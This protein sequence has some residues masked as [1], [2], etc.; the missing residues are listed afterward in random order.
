MSRG[1]GA[2]PREPYPA[3]VFVMIHSGISAVSTFAT[4][5]RQLA[6]C[7]LDGAF[8]DQSLPLEQ[9][10]TLFQSAIMRLTRAAQ[11]AQQDIDEPNV[12][13]TESAERTPLNEIA[14][15]ASP[16]QAVVMEEIHK[17]TP[18]RNKSKKGGKKGTK[19]K[20]GKAVEAEPVEMAAQVEEEIV[21]N[22]V[23]DAPVEEKTEEA[24]NGE[25]GT[26]TAS[27]TANTI[28]SDTVES[29]TVEDRPASPAHKAVRLTR[30]QLAKQEEEP[31]QSQQP[32]TS[33]KVEPVEEQPVVDDIPR[34]QTEATV[35]MEAEATAEPENVVEAEDPLDAMHTSQAAD[36]AASGAQED[37]AFEDDEAADQIGEKQAP[38][39]A[40]A[41]L[42]VV[43]PIKNVDPEREG[44]EP[45]IGITSDPEPK[46]LAPERPSDACRT[47][48]ISR[49]SS[50]RAS[51]SPSKSPMRI[52]E[53]IEALDALEEALENVGKAVSHFDPSTADKSPRKQALP[54]EAR[55]PSARTKT[56]RKTTLASRV[57]RTPSAAPKSIKPTT[58]ALAR[59]SS[60]RVAPAK[61]LR[62]RSTE[63]VDYLASNRRPV[64]ISFPT[65]P[66][67][68]K[69]RAPTKPTFQLSSDAVAAKLKAQKEERLKREAEREARGVVPKQRPI[70]MPPVAKSTKA[71]TKATFQL[72]GEAVAAK[73]K[74]QK[75]ERLNR[76]AQS[77]Q[78]DQPKPR[79]VSISMPPPTMKSTKA[80]TKANFQLP[81]EAVAA[82]LKAQREERQKREEEAGAVKK[83]AASK[84]RSAPIR[85]PVALP[86]RSQPGVTI[87]PP[88][89]KSDTLQPPSQRSASTSSKRN[90]IQASRSTSV[91]TTASNRNSVIV[92]KAMVT[93]VDA[94]QQKLKGKEVFN[95][96]KNEKEAKERERREKEEAAKQA[97]AQAAERGRIASREWAEKQR[98]KMLSAVKAKEEAAGR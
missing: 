77:S 89:P 96:D 23:E 90:S 29:S 97:R 30:R 20:K 37:Q 12:N 2:S 44:V 49:T 39:I 84:A 74:A 4:T 72:P 59:A 32:A 54:K 26:T 28:P 68:P 73:L 16:K 31:R 46:T 67:P 36:Y 64:S 55:T 91:S 9:F 53:S 57:S 1:Q 98:Q 6:R 19:A 62:K 75:E 42:E 60:V 22:A 71:P 15:N 86:T 27:T 51:R 63:T 48:I 34:N 35:D 3:R 83:A 82:K 87:P 79:P 47:P 85:K 7:F 70:S 18:A 92:P 33:L 81:G 80:P 76:V 11:R 52:E 43:L 5:P 24:A 17:K 8:A 25:C 56:P 65:P 38:E 21:D 50:R 88:H 41:K 78:G 13:A 10:D 93:P 94:V 61:D 14:P 95:R 40:K 58:T 69:G 66:P 45:S